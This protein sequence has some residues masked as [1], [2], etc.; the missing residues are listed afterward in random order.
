VRRWYEEDSRLFRFLGGRLLSAVFPKFQPEISH[1]LCEL[2]AA[3]TG[4]DADFVLAVMEN[5]HGEPETHEVLKRIVARYPDDQSKL[6]G[7]CI[8]FD[9]TEVVW[10]DFGFVEAMRQKK[11]ALNPW[12]A[13]PRPEVRA[14]AEKHN[15]ELDLRIADE[16]RRAEAEKALRELEYEDEEQDKNENGGDK[17]PKDS[18]R[19][20]D[21]Q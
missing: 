17:A 14:F 19:E 15:H 13:D 8:S 9:S 3:G 4:T 16:Q 7:V 21:N 11:A 1:E 2:V 18:D 10:G 6:S 12:L 20:N 5:Y